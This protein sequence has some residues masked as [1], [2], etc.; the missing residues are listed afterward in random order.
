MKDDLDDDAIVVS[1]IGMYGRH[2]SVDH[3]CLCYLPEPVIDRGRH[4]A[5]GL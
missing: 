3:G 4:I 2:C 1:F 5:F